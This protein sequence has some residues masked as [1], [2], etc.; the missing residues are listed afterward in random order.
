MSYYVYVIIINVTNALENIYYIY[1]DAYICIKKIW[2][3]SQDL[4]QKNIDIE[5]TFVFV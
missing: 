3:V 1:K 4:L 2:Y 5:E